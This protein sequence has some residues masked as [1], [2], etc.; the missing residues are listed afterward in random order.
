M[1]RLQAHRPRELLLVLLLL[2]VVVGAGLLYPGLHCCNLVWRYVFC[3]HGLLALAYLGILCWHVWCEWAG[4]LCHKLCGT[5]HVIEEVCW[6]PEL[7]S[8]A[9][10]SLQQSDG[11]SRQHSLPHSILRQHD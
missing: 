8:T 3:N 7:S 10:E 1:S 4:S 5:A 2:L 6:A 9:G 11:T